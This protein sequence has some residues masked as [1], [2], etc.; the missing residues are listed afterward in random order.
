MHTACHPP[1]RPP[2]SMLYSLY[3]CHP[4][5]ALQSEDKKAVDELAGEVEAKATVEDKAE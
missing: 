5:W 1:I 3:P 4:A 2:C